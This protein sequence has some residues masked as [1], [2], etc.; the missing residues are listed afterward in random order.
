MINSPNYH[1]TI[2]NTEIHE[3]D[4]VARVILS[5]YAEYAL[6]LSSDTWQ[7]YSEDILDVH[8]RMSEA[9]LIV[10]VRGSEFI[11][12]AT[13]FP[14][15]ENRECVTW[16]DDW[17]GIRLVGVIPSYRGQGIAR[18][19]MEECILRSRRQG[20]IAVGLHTTPL[21]TIAAKL[22]ENMGFVRAYEHENPSS[23]STT[24]AYKLTL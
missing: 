8:S 10:A 23:E 4:Q 17:T 20:A 19:L 15:G 12:S 24:M 7:Q 22:Y 21:M 6:N 14:M 13:F 1:I 16:P 9:D 5:A 2:R 3:L 11:G 18:M